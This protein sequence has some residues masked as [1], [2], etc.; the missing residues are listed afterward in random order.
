MF[1]QTVN[2]DNNSGL[3]TADKALSI[4]AAK[5]VNTNSDNFV[6]SENWKGA[7]Q[8]GGI[9]AGDSEGANTHSHYMTGES[10]ISVASLDNEA[11]RIVSTGKNTIC[12]S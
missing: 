12:T 7:N 9:Y 8:A 3:I 10:I 1:I 6:A 4:S 11:G 5:L 2:L